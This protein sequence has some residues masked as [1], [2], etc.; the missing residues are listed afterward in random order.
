M[1]TCSLFFYILTSRSAAG[2]GGTRGGGFGGHGHGM[3]GRG[4]GRLRGEPNDED[5]DDMDLEV[6]GTGSFGNTLVL[7]RD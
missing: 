7:Q 4:R 5:L 3:G 2:R 1:S 6:Y